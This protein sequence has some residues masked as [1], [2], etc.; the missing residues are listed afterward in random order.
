MAPPKS[1]AGALIAA[2]DA[3]MTA[4]AAKERLEAKMVVAEVQLDDLRRVACDAVEYGEELRRDTD[5]DTLF[6]PGSEARTKRVKALCQ[7]CHVLSDGDAPGLVHAWLSDATGGGKPA[8]H[9]TIGAAVRE[10]V[11]PLC[12]AAAG[13]GHTALD[14]LEAAG[15]ACAG[16]TQALG[17]GRT[18]RLMR[19]VLLGIPAQLGL[20]F[21]AV[22]TAGFDACPKLYANVRED[23]AYREEEH[24]GNKGYDKAQVEAIQ[25]EWESPL[26][27]RPSDQ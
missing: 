12:A 17:T 18:A 4:V 1:A 22:K 13:A 5:F 24:R 14:V 23:G 26:Y 11:E 2:A 6:K 20:A 27:S 8:P 9:R 16:V 3:A 10:R 15:A 21:P 25:R 7:C 19:R